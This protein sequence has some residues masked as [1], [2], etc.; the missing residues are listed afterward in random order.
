MLGWICKTFTVYTIV[1]KLQYMSYFCTSC[2]T[3]AL[4]EHLHL[5]SPP[6]FSG[7][8]IAQYLIFCVLFCRSLFVLFL[9]AIVLSVLRFTDSDFGNFKLSGHNVLLSSSIECVS[10]CCFMPTQ[11]FFSYIKA[12]TSSFSVRW[13]WSPLCTRPTCWVGFLY[14]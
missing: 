11:Q 8:R 12:R 2:G 5:S 4:P 7:V 9:L 1:C 10:D 3:V 6:V 14:C 13:W